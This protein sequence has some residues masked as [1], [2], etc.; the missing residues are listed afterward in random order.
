MSSYSSCR[1]FYGTFG[2]CLLIFQQSGDDETFEWN[3]PERKH[4]NPVSL[5]CPLVAVQDMPASCRVMYI[6]SLVHL[7][8]I[9]ITSRQG[10]P[11]AAEMFLSE[12]IKPNSFLSNPEV[13]ETN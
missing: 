8:E 11:L 2:K 1:D 10:F 5:F 9:Q 7:H 12:V 13:S 4:Q 3:Q 6:S